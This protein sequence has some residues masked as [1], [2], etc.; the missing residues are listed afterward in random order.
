MGRWIDLESEST[1]YLSAP[2]R[3]AGP[4]VLVFHAWW[5]LNVVFR[6]VC[7]RLAE[8][9]FL[10]LAPDLYGDHSIATTIEA[11]ESLLN[12]A[13]GAAMTTRATAGFDA[14]MAAAE[15]SGSR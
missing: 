3:G 13:D 2:A 11:A 1:A 5:G 6:D 9:G 4:G 12:D 10:A 8:N 15:R 7:D 14:L